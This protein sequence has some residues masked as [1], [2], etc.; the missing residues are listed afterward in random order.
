MRSFFLFLAVLFYVELHENHVVAETKDMPIQLGFEPHDTVMDPDNPVMYMT[1]LGSKTLYA[2]NYETGVVS[3][4]ALPYPAERLELYQDKLYVTQHKMSHSLDKQDNLTGA[5]AEVNKDEFKVI[6]IMD[7]NTDPFDIAIDEHGFI[8]ISNGSSQ[9]ASITVYSL[10]DKV[11]IVNERYRL[12]AQSYIQYNAE[13]SKLYAIGTRLSPT[14]VEA[15]EVVKGKIKT[16]YNSPY[17][18]D[19]I[20]QSFA[21]ISP[22]GL[23]MYNRS[24]VVFELATFQS[25]DMNFS[26]DL[27]EKYNDY[28]FDVENQ[29]TFAANVNGGIDVY[30]YG[31][32]EYIYS[33]HMD[34]NVKKLHF[35]DGLMIVYEDDR[36]KEYT[37][38]SKDY[39]IGNLELFKGLTVHYDSYDKVFYKNFYHKVQNVKIDSSIMLAFNQAITVND[40]EKIY[41]KSPDS[42]VDIEKDVNRGVLTI[43]PPYLEVD[44]KYTLVIEKEALSNHLGKSLQNDVEIEFQTEWLP[45]GWVKEDGSWYY[46]S[47]TTHQ[48]VK[49]LQEIDDS[50]YYFNSWGKLQ[51]GWQ[52]IDQEMYYFHENGVMQTEWLKL[53]GKWYYFNHNGKMQTGCVSINCF[54]ENGVM[55]TGWFQWDNTWYYLDENGTMASGWLQ[56]DNKWYY[57]N[58]GKGMQTGWVKVKKN[59]YYFNKDGA[60]QIGWLYLDGKWYY[61]DA[62]G[63]KRIGW[64]QV[65]N[66]RYY[67]D[68][69][70][71][72]KTGWLQVDGT[73]YYFKDSGAMQTGWFQ[74]GGKW[75][76]LENSGAMQTGW[77]QESGKWYYFYNNGQMAVNTRIDGYQI[78]KDGVWVK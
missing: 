17:H 75:Y 24:G 61:L 38:Y 50:Y 63:A 52:D 20:L 27:G 55:Q 4:L 37:K 51:T 72:M 48:R 69:T 44:T 64:L 47:E 12:Y 62:S 36:G 10:K 31:T 45:T 40:S 60:M 66:T 74:S 9:W 6:D 76:Y 68:N 78:N 19:Y 33:L 1:K 16:Y 15:F 46:Y 25:G 26:F 18:G 13:T 71:V 59:E 77:L 42:L 41:L 21:K 35:Q 53:D 11:E 14:D 43:D 56:L 54:D 58:Y 34:L 57:F 67:F 30:K 3:T 29:L 28:A 7:I 8:Y 70:G 22:D 23:H 39:K 73:W 5:I 32:D 65:G 49:G 2:V